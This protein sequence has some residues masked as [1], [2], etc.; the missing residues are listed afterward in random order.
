MIRLAV[1][2]PNKNAWSETFIQA[3]RERLFPN[4]SFFYGAWLPRFTPE[5]KH[6]LSAS[7]V[8]Q[9][10]V[11]HAEKWLG[12]PEHNRLRKALSAELKNRKVEVVLAEY[13][14]SGVEMHEVC[15]QLGIPLVVHFHG[16]DVYDTTLLAEYGDRYPTMF[17]SAAALVAVS[18]EM[19]DR[20]LE[21]GAPAEKL[22]W[23]PCGPDLSLFT[24]T[25]AGD[26]PPV[27]LAAGRFAAT[28]AP[29]LTV[30]AFALAAN[31]VADL[32]LVMVGEGQYLDRCKQLVDEYGLGNRVSFKGVLS[33]VEVAAEM[34]KARA[35]V[36]H[37][38]R[39]STGDSEGT[40]V[41]IQEAGAAGLPVI[42]TRHAGIPDVVEDQKTG[43]LVE[44]GDVEAMARAM[45]RLAKD[46]ELATRMGTAARHHIRTHFSLEKHL[47]KLR[48]IIHQVTESS[49]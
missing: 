4:T 29:W 2:S 36:Q 21:M 5:G 6:L 23:N 30:E 7:P 32:Q 14:P 28:K 37:S 19:Q 26:N 43:I 13:G 33:H 34:G 10:V 45:V 20:L 46:P 38:Q 39:T 18:R 42:S 47:E 1:I 3:H 9:G 12:K 25:V 16:F 8:V 48:G 17:A 22:H 44:E 40:P 11:Y 41:A 15:E 31:E 35:F 27:L 49:T 24:P